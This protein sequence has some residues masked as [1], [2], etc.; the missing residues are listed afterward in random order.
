MDPQEIYIINQKGREWDHHFP[1][2]LSKQVEL[3]LGIMT[4]ILYLYKIYS[5]GLDRDG[6]NLISSSKGR[7]PRQTSACTQHHER[8][9]ARTPGAS[10][11]ASTRAWSRS[12]PWCISGSAEASGNGNPSSP[13]PAHT[14]PRGA[15][16]DA[17]SPLHSSGSLLLLLLLP[18]PSLRH[19]PFWSD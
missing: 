18:V 9:A 13:D 3:Q 10:S 8:Q 7:I 16:D 12:Q 14:S 15:A 11:Q 17:H 5:Y 1:E 19:F 6:M 2:S 4:C